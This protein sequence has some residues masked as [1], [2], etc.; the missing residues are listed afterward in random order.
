MSWTRCHEP[1]SASPVALVSL[2]ASGGQEQT[3][4]I[5]DF[6]GLG[7]IPEARRDRR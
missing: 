7:R 1:A 4:G 5:I 2:R 3:I 6:Y